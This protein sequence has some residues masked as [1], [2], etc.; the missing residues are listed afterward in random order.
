MISEICETG[1]Q[2]SSPK[3]CNQ[4]WHPDLQMPSYDKSLWCCLTVPNFSSWSN[5]ALKQ[6]VK[7]MFVVY[8]YPCSIL[9]EKNR[10]N[11]QC[12]YFDCAQLE[13]H[14]FSTLSLFFS[15]L[16]YNHPC[17]VISSLSLV[18]MISRKQEL[19][20]VRIIT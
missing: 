1:F 10:S 17:E 5:M 4:S 7:Y 6:S 15:L 19:S 8:Q 18:V 16:L 20:C 2:N 3:Q 9:Q 12:Y 11:N 13:K 14:V